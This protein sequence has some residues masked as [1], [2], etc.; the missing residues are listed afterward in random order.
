MAHRQI[1]YRK[2]SSILSARFRVFIYVALTLLNSPIILTT[3]VAVMN[4]RMLCLSIIRIG[5][6][7]VV[8]IVNLFCVVIYPFWGPYRPFD[9]LAFIWSKSQQKKWEFSWEDDGFSLVTVCSAAK[10]YLCVIADIFATRTRSTF[11][12]RVQRIFIVPLDE[13]TVHTVRA[14]PFS[15]NTVLTCR[16]S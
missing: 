4:F 8:R 1:E 12:V 3:I 9:H 11:R 10:P 14:R 2:S 15:I 7:S 13:T 16:G 5:P 6:S